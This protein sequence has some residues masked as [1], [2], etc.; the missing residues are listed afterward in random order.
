MTSRLIRFAGFGLVIL[1]AAAGLSAWLVPP[2]LDWN[3][4]RAD[5]AA[6]VSLNLGREVTIDGPVSLSLLP[7]PVL[8]AGAV[9]VVGAAADATGPVTARVA[10]LRVSLALGPL[11]S[12]HV[13]AREV[14]LRGLDMHLPF[15]LGRDS[16]IFR[17]PTWLSSISA[18]IEDGTLSAGGVA[19]T[20]IDAQLGLVPDTGST[21]LAGTAEISGQTWHMTARLTRS[22]V[23]GTSGLDLSLD[24]QGPV[25]GLGAMFSGQTAADGSLSG[26]ISGRGP[27]LSRLIAAP[28][29]PFHADGRLSIAAG[30]AVADD[31]A[32]EIA[33][34]PARGAV[35]LR[36]QPGPRLDVSLAAS[37]LDLDTWLPALLRGSAGRIVASIPT[38][39]DLSSEAATLAG[40]TLRG[41]RGSFELG[42][43]AVQM[44]DAEAVL[45]GDA[46]MSLAGTL[47]RDSA[48]ESGLSLDGAASVTAPDLRATLAW[49]ESAGLGTLGVL[50]TAVLRTADLRATVKAETGP[51]PRITLTELNGAIDGAHAAGSLTVRPGPRL[52]LAGMLNLDRVALDDWWPS[53]LGGITGVPARF[54]KLNLD[55]QLHADLVRL[56]GQNLAPAA[57]DLLVEPTRVTLRRL[58]V[59]Q[60]TAKLTASGSLQDNGRLT[61]AR[62]D[63]TTGADAAAPLIAA[64]FPSLNADTAHVPHGALTLAV[65]AA[66]P[67]E[68]LALRTTLDLG[69]LHAE[70]APTFDLPGSRWSAT[71]ALRHPGAP[72]LLDTIG[73]GGT[74]S[75]LGDGSL[76]WAGTIVGTG[77]ILAPSRI[78]SDNFDMAAGGLRARGALA[79]DRTGLPRLTG[80][81]S[82]DTLPLPLP[83]PRAPDPL[84][85][86]LLAGWKASLKLEAGQVLFG[87]SPLLQ[88]FS[89]TMTVADGALKIDDIAAA[90]DGGALAG[91]VQVDGASTPTAVKA[92]LSLR[93]SHPSGAV[94]DLPLDITGGAMDVSASLAAQGYAPVA[95]LSTLSGSIS[96]QSRSGVLDGVDLAQCG[97]RLEAADLRQALSGGTT[98]FDGF[99]IKATLTSGAARITDAAMTS[100]S[101]TATLTGLI[102]LADRTTELRLTVHPP[103]AD[104]PEIALRL[105]GRLD[106]ASRSLEI[107][108][109]LRW[110]AQHPPAP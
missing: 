32:V 10:E 108:D 25:Q 6:F 69:D 52:G 83:Y 20:H 51:A 92:E 81:L 77:P 43:N 19:A 88:K 63:V 82:A 96:V 46:R 65:T 15:P 1:V 60:S 91:S 99:D 101:G 64:W 104:P 97:P 53:E 94:F 109:A 72:R 84:P 8:T 100:A 107:S 66:G 27:D 55:L 4:Y 29:V 7:E 34:S 105:S 3:R 26:R 21:T 86:A 57:L 12:G 11:L 110:R 90:L 30:L 42:P 17:V 62:L 79:L 44:R 22:G 54:G 70:A 102:D 36:L 47:R 98:P 5:L 95:L 93:G 106:T 50:P 87:L 85:V 9:S 103:V 14:V 71:M 58:E 23:D 56:R 74:A 73:L 89:A 76:S 2:M 39:I 28:A 31:L 24:G 33:G 13:D 35:S 59:Q 41:L 61:D 67:V 49:L 37:R 68:A 16:L 18:R 48:A 38:G 40:G 80:R 78:A 75:W 45:P